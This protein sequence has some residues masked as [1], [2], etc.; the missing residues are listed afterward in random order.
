MAFDA[1][2]GL[3]SVISA[4]QNNLSHLLKHRHVVG[5]GVGYKITASGPTDELAVVINVQRKLPKDQ[6]SASD[7]IPQT[8]GQVRTDVI[9]TGIIRAFQGHKDRWRP[10]IPAGVSIGLGQATS[11]TFGCLV[12][13]GDDVFILSNNH[14][15]ADVNNGRQGDPIIQ[16]GDY[17]GGKAGDKIAELADYAPIDFGDD[18][19][20]CQLAEI[21]AQLLNVLAKIG[22]S[23]HRLT[24]YQETPGLNW[25]DA[26]LAKPLNLAVFKAD[27]LGIGRPLGSKEVGLGDEV[28]KSGRTTGYTE[29][30][31]IQIEVTTSVMYGG[32]AAT[33]S[34]QLMANAMSAPG[35]SGS[36]VLDKQNYA[37]GLLFAG[38]NN[39][40][41]INP[42][43]RVL[44]ALKVEIVT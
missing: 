11:G 8:I 5:V 34:G 33:F 43:S 10:E 29:G 40:T 35:D 26:A 3:G 14:V 25:V 9:E 28:K 44:T 7:L 24:A 13:R 20:G 19:P 1:G 39:V 38:S 36:I 4:K 32:R 12:R 30:Q 16:P 22:G 2:G 37:V 42:I 27:I 17:D 15:L 41:L 21:A 23:K 6:L 31:I 18:P